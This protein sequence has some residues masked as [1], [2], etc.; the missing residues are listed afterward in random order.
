[1]TVSRL[2]TATLLAIAAAVA[3]VA[4]AAASGITAHVELSD[5]MRPLLRAGDVVWLQR[6]GARDARVGDVVAFDDPRGDATLLHREERIRRDAFGR[7]AF[8]TR[9]DANDEAESWAIER[10]GSLGRYA[11][12]RVPVVGRAVLALQGPP[13]AAIALLSGLALAMLALRRIWSS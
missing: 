4:G 12:F 6:V 1:M 7:L 5:S 3:A 11:G 9:G 2:L 13:L 8:T 10:D